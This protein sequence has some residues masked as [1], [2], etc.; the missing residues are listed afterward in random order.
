MRYV[1]L[2]GG[3]I[4]GTLAGRLAERSQN[5]TVLA[6]GAHARVL[7][8]SGLRLAMPDRT[9]RLHVPVA[10]SLD[11]LRLTDGD[12]LVLAVK[13]QHTEQLVRE[14]AWLHADGFPAGLALPL[15]C[16]QNGVENERIALRYFR[17][18]YGMCLSVPAVHIEPGR[19]DAL[20]E[21]YGGVID[22][23]RY[24]AGVDET[25]ARTVADLNAA[26]FFC[27]AQDRIMRWKYGKLLRNLDNVVKILLPAEE[28]AANTGL[29]RMV[30]D[31]AWK[32]GAACLTAAGIDFVSDDEWNASRSRRYGVRP[33]EGRRH[34]GNSTWQSFHRGTGNTEADYL[35]G[36]IVLVG[37]S[38]GFPTPVNEALQR[39]AIEVAHGTKAPDA[40][41]LGGLAELC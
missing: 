11:Q 14:L 31:A 8:T 16:A 40:G 2:G 32:E 1:V 35:N 26:G 20:G 36:E 15:I 12:V 6:R 33:V 38:A 22:I 37:R 21:P 28:Y 41:I 9:V 23:G 39:E 34:P 27:V 7:R 3:A 30:G 17:R 5:V 24:A 29:M 13:S 18:V 19:V 25:V 10:E 4:G